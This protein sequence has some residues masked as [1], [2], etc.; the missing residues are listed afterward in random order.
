MHSLP[1]RPLTIGPMSPTAIDRVRR[2]ET[3][4]ET[5]PQIPILTDHVLHAGMYARTIHVPAGTMITGALI[6]VPTILTL[7]GNAVIYVG[8]DVPLHCIGYTVLTAAAGRKQ[9]ILAETDICLTMIFPTKARTVAEAEAAFTDDF[10]RLAS[11]RGDTPNL[12]VITGE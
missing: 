11:R 9:A 10:A 3:V 5:L 4:A 1:A 12:T 8:E 2:I 7:H 6:K